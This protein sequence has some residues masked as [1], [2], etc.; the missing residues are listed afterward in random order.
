MPER[1]IGPAP[2]PAKLPLALVTCSPNGGPGAL[3]ARPPSSILRQ[4]LRCSSCGEL[5]CSA[6]SRSGKLGTCTAWALS[7]IRCL[8]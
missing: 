1:G 4:N 2:R 5:S 7:A 3:T 8:R 6:G